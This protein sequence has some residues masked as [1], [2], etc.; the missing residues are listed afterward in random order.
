M[1]NSRF[2]PFPLEAIPEPVRSYIEEGAASLGCDPTYLAIPLLT[3]IASAIGSSR[4]IE[5]KSTWREPAIL[6]TAIVGESGT[7]KSPAFDLALEPV[8]NRQEEAM[9]EWNERQREYEIELLRYEKEFATWRADKNSRIDPPEK[10]QEPIADRYAVQDQTTEALAEL[11]EKQPRG[12]LMFRDELAGWFAGFDRYSQAKGGDS[13]RWLELHRGGSLIV[14]RK[15]KKLFVSGAYVSVT[16]GIQPGT[17][18]KCFTE[19]YR[20]N[21]LAARI[22]LASPPRKP[23]RW[24]ERTITEETAQSL[25]SLFGRLYDLEPEVDE[26]G[27]QKPRVVRLNREA[28]E[29]WVLFY[30]IHNEQTIKLSGDMASFW[31][32]LEG[33]APRLALIHHCIRLAWFDGTLEAEDIVDRQSIEAGI[34]MANWF[35]REAKRIYASM[36]GRESKIDELIGTILDHGGGITV[37]QLQ[38]KHRHRYPKAEDAEKALRELVRDGL[39]ASSMTTPSSSGGHPTEV[40]RLIDAN[41]KHT[42]PENPTKTEVLC[43]VSPANRGNSGGGF[44]G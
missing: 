8:L 3:A 22:L 19:A 27:R 37:R 10:P 35:G 41:T 36:A 6:W 12:L 24:T 4:R 5:L 26:T 43:S 40:F 16:G 39:V 44:D 29:V 17:L 2:E 33:Y 31:S 23:K 28:K 30:D 42:T 7:M 15:S 38:S 25:K 20:E 13:A 18:K 32:K 34:A 14:D 9:R 11:L 1:A 21:G